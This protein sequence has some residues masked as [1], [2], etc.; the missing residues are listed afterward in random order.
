M[1]FISRNNLV[2]S[3]FIEK[4]TRLKRIFFADCRL[5][6][7]NS[8]LFSRLKF[9]DV[10]EDSRVL[11]LPSDALHCWL[12]QGTAPGCALYLS[13]CLLG[14]KLRSTS[15]AN[16]AECG[17]CRGTYIGTGKGEKKLRGLRVERRMDLHLPSLLLLFFFFILLF[18]S[19]Y[20]SLWLQET[21]VSINMFPRAER[22]EET[23]LYL[24]LFFAYL[25]LLHN[26]LYVSSKEKN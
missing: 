1:R 12:N 16:I 22:P 17:H 5:C 14:E 3:I 13:R 21:T 7:K 20:C 8:F 18:F 9:P 25:I 23:L 15:T 10:S 6:G 24:V 26:Y 19:H 2:F 4:R 11:P